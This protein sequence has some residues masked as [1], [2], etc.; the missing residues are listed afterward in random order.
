MFVQWKMTSW[1]QSVL[2]LPKI[3]FCSLLYLLHPQPIVPTCHGQDMIRSN[4]IKRIAFGSCFNPERKQKILATLAQAKPDIMLFL[5]DNIYADTFVYEEM[6]RHYDWL[7]SQKDFQKIQE[8]TLVTAGVWDDH[9]FGINDV[10]TE[11]P[12]KHQ[13]KKL[14]W[15]LF[16]S[17]RPKGWKERPG[18]YSSMVIG[19]KGRRV[20]IIILDTRFNRDK[21]SSVGKSA[22]GRTLYGPGKGE[23]LGAQQW[24]WLEKQL[25]VKAD[26]RIV[27]SSIQVLNNSHP[28]EK[29]G[30]FPHERQRLIDLLVNKSKTSSKATLLLSGDRHFHEL[31]KYLPNSGAEK[32]E[33]LFE[34]TSSGLNA[35]A[36]SAGR[37]T[38]PLRVRSNNQDGFGLLEINWK[39]RSLALFSADTNGKQV[40]WEK[41]LF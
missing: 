32:T 5:G 15:G 1:F 38:N 24:A 31:S 30:N 6:K 14:F 3:L 21:L 12:N 25:N 8:R 16:P 37:E 13:F 19:G 41:L 10:G 28:F 17:Y 4:T 9:D 39:D 7:K 2:I 18:V 33:P 36:A 26:L 23:V 29:W 34:F 20:Q 27:A 40:L 11:H 35:T 22:L